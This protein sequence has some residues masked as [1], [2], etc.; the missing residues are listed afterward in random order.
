MENGVTIRDIGPQPQSFDIEQASKAN[1]DY[2]AVAWS[3]RYSQVTLVSIP[4]GGEIGLQAHPQTDQFLRLDTGQG[5]AQM[6]A[7]KSDLSFEQE[8]SDGCC[9]LDPAGTWHNITNIATTPM[10]VYTI[11]A[12]ADHQ[13]GQL[14]ATAAA[15]QADKDDEPAT[16]SVRSTQALDKHG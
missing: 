6:G 5:R 4:A 7:S 3:G 10:Q 1:S 8:V 11:Y 14:Q 9:V 2:R 15:T 12:P 16:R 13:P